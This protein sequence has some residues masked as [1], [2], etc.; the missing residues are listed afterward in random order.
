MKD[1]EKIFRFAENEFLFLATLFEFSVVKR[2]SERYGCFIY[3]ANPTTGVRVSYEP[4]ESGVFVQLSELVDGQFPPYISEVRDGSVL[5]TFDLQ[6][7]RGIRGEEPFDDTG[8]EIEQTLSAA[9]AAL[10]E[11]GELVLR[12]D[13]R[14]FALL[15][16][17]VKE[18]ARKFR[19]A[20][21]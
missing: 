11:S 20:P 4:F 13:F 3:F 12:G 19:N 10:K 5:R 17:L 14:E 8:E 2:E 18:R 9:A 16:H 6:D 1:C 21:R 15:D 7:L